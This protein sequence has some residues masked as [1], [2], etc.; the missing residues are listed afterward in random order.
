LTRWDLGDP[1]RI[2]QA[3]S[4]ETTI[5]ATPAQVRAVAR[6]LETCGLIRVSGPEAM[7]RLAAQRRGRGFDPV[8][9]LIKNY[10]FIRIRLVNPDRFLAATLPLIGGLFTRSFLRIVL[11]AALGGFLVLRQWTEFVTNL[12]ALANPGG[13]LMIGAALVL[14]KILH[15]LGHGYTARRFGCRVPAMGIAFM[16]LWPVL[17]TD[18][19]DAWRLTNRRHRLAID[20][21]G[22]V[23]ELALAAFASILW[24]VLPDGPL[25]MAALMLAGT[26]WVTTLAVNL[27]PFMRFDG[28]FMLADALDV[29]NLSERS[30]ALAR[31]RLRE[32]LF[33]LGDQ[34]P[35][36]FSAGR[37]TLLTAHAFGTWIYRFILFFGIALLVYHLFFKALGLVLMLI[38][39]G[40]FIARPIA[41]ELRVWLKRCG[42]VRLNRHSA[43][44]LATLGVLAALVV[45]PWRHEIEAPALLHANREAV[46]YTTQP[47][48]LQVLPN[49]SAGPVPVHAGAECQA[50][51]QKGP[52]TT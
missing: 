41:G 9:W 30:F 8:L 19:T 51:S 36:L 7:R 29:A 38:E 44:T 6:F 4:R 37:R 26:T 5:E 2:A 27:N 43:A 11:A 1:E 10:L 50:T 15:E 3:V 32:L 48:Q 24:A 33:G 20:S 14:S 45:L 23:V 28:Y 49:A 39:I 46:L 52:L 12:Q 22:V 18:T 21:A 31:W 42:E 13:A 35:E 40:W 47:G 25:R 17:W 16:V 34:P